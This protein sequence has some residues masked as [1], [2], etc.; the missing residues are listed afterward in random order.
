MQP[1]KY[2]VSLQP[3]TTEILTLPLRGSVSLPKATPTFQKWR[4]DPVED[5]FG[6][7]TI[8]D[9]E[10]RPAFAELYILWTLQKDGW[11]GVW[12]DSYRHL[13]RT[14]YWDSEPQQSLP[15]RPNSVPEEIWNLAKIRSGVWDVFCWRGERVLF[16]ESKR[17]KSKGVRKDDI[18]QSQIDFAESALNIGLPL[19]SLLL[20]EWNTD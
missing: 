9:F 8:L 1:M 11:Q 5:N 4:G 14:G 7:K 20:V 13:F 10:G 12:V 6:G 2:P 15:E 3:T 16:A 17:A 19:D 18:Q